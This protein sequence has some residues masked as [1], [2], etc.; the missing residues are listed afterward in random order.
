MFMALLP[1]HSWVICGTYHSQE[2]C[3]VCRFASQA[4]DGFGLV[5]RTILVQNLIRDHLSVCIYI[6]NKFRHLL[7]ILTLVDPTILKALIGEFV[8]GSLSFT[9]FLL[10]LSNFLLG[11]WV[12][13]FSVG[14]CCHF[15]VACSITAVSTC[16]VSVSDWSFVIV[17]FPA[18]YCLVGWRVTTALD[19]V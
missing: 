5:W 13:R 19:S 11:L 7:C 17:I 9:E 1:H 8:P 18:G 12:C 14:V 2:L 3:G 6:Q 16:C 10:Y 4:S 15:V